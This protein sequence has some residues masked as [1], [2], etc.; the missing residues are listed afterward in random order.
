MELSDALKDRKERWTP[1]DWEGAAR[2]AQV[3]KE[4]GI[5]LT[6]V[7]IEALRKARQ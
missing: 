5:P 7:D 6:A 3:R 2:M 1:E 4:C